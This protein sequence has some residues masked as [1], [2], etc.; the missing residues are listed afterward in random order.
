MVHCV[1]TAGHPTST[2]SQIA[3]SSSAESPHP[4]PMIDCLPRPA[5]SF[6]ALHTRTFVQ[7]A[8]RTT[9][10]R[11]NIVTSDFRKNAMNPMTTIATARSRRSCDHTR[12]STLTALNRANACTCCGST[13]TDSITPRTVHVF[14]TPAIAPRTD[15]ASV[16]DA[17]PCPSC[18]ADTAA[19]LI[20]IVDSA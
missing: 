16:G 19:R 5:G 4:A 17:S 15:L 7:F 2:Q 1:D 12:P 11:S 14:A 3:C 6:F 20:A 13:T 8:S 9:S 10:Q 18:T